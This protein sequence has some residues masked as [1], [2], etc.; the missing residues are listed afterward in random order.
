MGDW[1]RLHI[2][3]LG[4]SLLVLIGVAVGVTALRSTP[5]EANPGMPEVQR[6][7]W[8]W[9]G[10][11]NQGPDVAFPTGLDLVVEHPAL[12]KL[13]LRLAEV[14]VEAEAADR[15]RQ[16]LEG[17]QPPDSLT[18]LYRDAALLRLLV[19]EDTVETDPRW[20]ALSRRPALD[21]TLARVIVDRGR[22]REQSTWLDTIEAGWAEQLAQDSSALGAAFG[23]GY[24][25]I[26]RFEWDTG[27]SLLQHALAL[28]PDDPQVHR[29]LGRIYFFTK[30]QDKLIAVLK[31]G[32]QA[33]EA[34]HDLELQLRL[35]GNLSM[36]LIREERDLD[37]AEQLIRE[38]IVQSRMLAQGSTEALNLSRLA[39]LL[40][41]Q[42]RYDEVLPLLDSVEVAY[43]R[44]LP[45]RRTEVL[46]LRGQ[47]LGRMYRFSEAE[48]VLE[49]TIAEAE[50]SGERV[51]INN[52]LASLA[53]IRYSMGRYTAA[54]E[55]GLEA[56]TLAQELDLKENEVRTLF[57]LGEIERRSGNFETAVEHL[58]Q[59]FVLAGE[60]NDRERYQRLAARLGIVALD[61]QD[62]NAAKE[63][64]ET[65]IA[66][67]EQENLPVELGRAYHGLGLTYQQFGNA[68]E[69]I[70]Y[71][72]LALAQ[73]AVASDPPFH[74]QV[75]MAKAWVL[76]GNGALEEAATLFREARRVAEQ[77]MDALDSRYRV[78]IG[79]GS[80]YLRQGRYQEAIERFQEA[81]AIEAGF[82]RPSLHWIALFEKAQAHW[83]FDQPQQADRAFREA[84][85]IIEA[86]RENLNS[87]TNRAYFVQN[88]VRVY[89]YFAAF[90]EEQ[91][92]VDEALY[93][94]ERARSRGLVDLLFTTQQA[95]DV[96][97]DRVADQVI[98]AERRV[99][100]L[101]QEI[102]EGTVPEEGGDAAYSATRA[103]Q[104]R[105]EYQTADSLY[106]QLRINLASE[107]P[108]YTFSPLRP[109]AV[110]ATL[111]DDEAMVVY[112]LR[113]IDFGAGPEDVSVVYVVLPDTIIVKP[114]E[115]QG[116]TLGE[117]IR[118]FRDQ[119]RSVG[120]GPNQ[121]WQPAARRLYRDLMGPVMAVLPPSTKHLHLVP[122]GLLHYLPFAA[123]QD[124]AGQ[125][126]VERY[127]LSV[128]PSASI[129]KLSRDSNPR[130]WRSMLL[131][132]DPD[133][134]LPGSR[135]EVKA[136]AEVGAANERLVLIGSDA[137]QAN[138]EQ[139]IGAYDILHF[140]THGR[141]FPRAPRNSHL[142]LHGE[143]VLSVEEIGRLNLN[144]YLVT[145]SACE[146]ALSAGLVADVPDGDEWVGLNQ[147]FLASG[148]PTVMASLWPIDDRISSDFMTDFYA[149]LG[150]EGKAH[151]L[152]D[153]QRRFLQ[154][155]ATN[156]PFYWAP[157]SVIG[158]P[159]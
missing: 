141:F 72:D 101:A 140:A 97:G 153:V 104:L 22:R 100:A 52:A 81:D 84:I 102:E 53:Q 125:F 79:L 131:L 87:S 159:L 44:H 157:F 5:L 133:G 115:V 10:T 158:D 59:A 119:L 88:K 149:T 73:F 20:Q 93:Y 144:A 45:Q 8:S 139:A 126:L 90:L 29:E 65:L 95:Q 124:D 107:E 105:Q 74:Y 39:R 78:E 1:L 51:V 26:L 57:I 66:S 46:A 96:K 49:E 69:A 129:L 75:L 18:R 147:A 24:A 56:L 114:L 76:I 19:P 55:V 132:G 156:H 122:E 118:F 21:P 82:R 135:T 16:T 34:R 41:S 91:G 121:P 137:T 35:R 89:E 15:C 106:Q 154:N 48:A 50:R 142:E 54:R 70:R 116:Q 28:V 145:L 148:T 64:F 2:W 110:Q 33:A 43:V 112:D 14:C 63:Y 77:S 40:Y 42:H 120:E 155:P 61:L 11:I 138:L 47:V 127:T 143:D 4:L 31:E 13:Y 99:R 152:A 25:T 113:S 94:T 12:H 17:L 60:I 68:S 27:E 117:T 9:V 30:Q 108:I 71:Y 151:A 130:R 58:E 36:T 3:Q 109:G 32:I 85:D 83:R 128:T 7:F 62:A 92:R 80:V 37:R 150:P 111:L 6:T 134:R 136:V 98:E 123:L 146:T 103:S 23:L 67:V 86:L 38:A